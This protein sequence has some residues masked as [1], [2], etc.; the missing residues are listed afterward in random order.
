MK[1]S[2]LFAFACIAGSCAT[3]ANFA[4]LG[5]GMKLNI[6]RQLVAAEA[7]FAMAPETMEHG[8]IEA[9]HAFVGDVDHTRAHGNIGG[10][11]MK[12]DGHNYAPVYARYLSRLLKK[13]VQPTIVE[14]GIL[15][16][17][18]LAMWSS[19][20]PGSNIYGFD[21]KTET[22]EHFLE[23]LKRK[24]FND[25]HVFVNRMDQT[26]D[27]S[28]VLDSVFR[29]NVHPNV[30]IDDGLHNVKA[31]EHTYWEF[32]HF[33]A[34]DFV[35]FVEDLRS[36]EIESGAWNAFGARIRKQC[37]SCEQVIDCPKG[38]GDFACMAVITSLAR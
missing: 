29:Q 8:L 38:H 2:G 31:S 14:T 18:G 4:S 23:S 37:K 32:Q 1:F 28:L 36:A 21:W 27:N 17:T 12:P 10:D 22:Y 24:G 25:S 6:E 26:K 15:T 33:L 34:A 7:R 3:R 30:I 16:G 19:I 35:Y 5:N 20:F 13:G 9:E 11:R